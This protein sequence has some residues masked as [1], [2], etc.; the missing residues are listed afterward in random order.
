M[1]SSLIHGLKTR[2]D[3]RKP[4]MKRIGNDQG[5]DSLG[6]VYR[7]GIT[8]AQRSASLRKNR[9]KQIQRE[10]TNRRTSCE[11]LANHTRL[12]DWIFVEIV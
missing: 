11:T 12:F 1:F 5:L 6:I 4:G 9:S 7:H 3:T 10:R 8:S 2:E